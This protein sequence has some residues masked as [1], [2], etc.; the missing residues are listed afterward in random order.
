MAHA[1]HI[2][3]DRTINSDLILVKPNTGSNEFLLGGFYKL[4]NFPSKWCSPA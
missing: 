4:I 3:G 2:F 1:K